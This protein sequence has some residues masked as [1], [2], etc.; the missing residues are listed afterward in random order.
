MTVACE[1]KL[2]EEGGQEISKPFCFS[3]KTVCVYVY[4]LC[5][6][7]VCMS[8]WYLCMYVCMVSLCLCERKNM[9]VVCVCFVLG[10][11]R[12]NSFACFLE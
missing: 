1:K 4:M 7:Y 6:V 12:G 5:G 9:Y 2:E 10:D 3:S 8:V 11:F